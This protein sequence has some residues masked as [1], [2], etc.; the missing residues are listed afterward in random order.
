MSVPRV[1][2]KAQIREECKWVFVS[3]T[4]KDPSD[5]NVLLNK[6][7]FKKGMFSYHFQ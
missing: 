4:N 6:K 7:E 5:P 3:I 2:R 1:A